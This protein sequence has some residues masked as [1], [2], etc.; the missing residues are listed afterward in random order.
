MGYSKGLLQMSVWLLINSLNCRDNGLWW[1]WMSL[2]PS[3]VQRE[4]I[5]CGWMK[6]CAVFSK[7]AFRPRLSRQGNYP[8]TLHITHVFSVARADKSF[9]FYV[10]TECFYKNIFSKSS[11]KRMFMKHQNVSDLEAMFS[12]I[13]Q[14][15]TLYREW[16]L[17]LS[18]ADCH[19]KTWVSNN[20][21]WHIEDRE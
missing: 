13:C 2:S 9:F 4:F 14:I 1:F 21:H 3:V 10:F 8:S 12:A 17:Q 16:N 7:S 19:Y 6:E 15:Q 20:I 5:H 11:V 18:T